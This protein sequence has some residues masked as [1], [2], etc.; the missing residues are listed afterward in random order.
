MIAFTT[1][2]INEYVDFNMGSDFVIG[3]SRALE[4]FDDYLDKAMIDVSCEDAS[5]TQGTSLWDKIKKIVE[6]VINFF[7]SLLNKL[8]EFIKKYADRFRKKGKEYKANPNPKNSIKDH[9]EPESKDVRIS[10]LEDIVYSWIDD[11]FDEIKKDSPTSET[12]Y[13]DIENKYQGFYSKWKQG[14][15]VSVPSVMILDFSGSSWS[16]LIGALSEQCN[17]LVDIKNFLIKLSNRSKDQKGSESSMRALNRMSKADID[18]T[19]THDK[20]A[21]DPDKRSTKISN[22]KHPI[23]LVLSLIKS[24]GASVKPEQLRSA[25]MRAITFVRSEIHCIFSA[26][27]HGVE[28]FHLDLKYTQDKYHNGRK[29][30]PIFK[31]YK[32]PQ[33]VKTELSELMGEYFKNK[34]GKLSVTALVVTSLAGYHKGNILTGTLYGATA[35]KGYKNDKGKGIAGRGSNVVINANIVVEKPLDVIVS[36]VVHECAHVYN[37]QAQKFENGKR[38][39]QNQHAEDGK[40]YKNNYSNDPDENF[41]NEHG[42]KAINNFLSRRKLR[43]VFSW[44]NMVQTEIKTLAAGKE[45]S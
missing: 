32:F 25:I 14:E 30:S 17:K 44:L 21:T 36:T 18:Q 24:D 37:S 40:S 41:A 27:K 34:G 19:I 12:V 6:T 45:I 10:K 29:V 1:T 7:K 38:V 9:K 43:S 26:I 4:S 20:N 16:S 22:V 31:V 23:S 15:Y 33:D 11:I 8:K 42:N 2:D 3:Y 39:Y 35:S 5:N 13:K 28:Y